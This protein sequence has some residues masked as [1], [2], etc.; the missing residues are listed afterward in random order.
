M[1]KT[2][3]VLDQVADE[4]AAELAAV[5]PSDDP[6]GAAIAAAALAARRAAEEVS[7]RD[8]MIR[9]ARNEGAT[10]RALAAATGLSHQTIANISKARSE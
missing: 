10:L 4:A 8:R 6:V 2:R 7:V 9:I 5:R 1:A 3:D